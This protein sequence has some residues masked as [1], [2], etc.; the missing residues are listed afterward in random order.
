MSNSERSRYKTSPCLANPISMS[1]WVMLSTM[2]CLTN[3]PS[4]TKASCLTFILDK[5]S[6]TPSRH[7]LTVF[8]N[9][10][11]RSEGP[12]SYLRMVSSTPFSS[13]GFS[14]MAWLT[15]KYNSPILW[16]IFSAGWSSTLRPS[17]SIP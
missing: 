16:S 4:H 12:L 14:F 10:A 5:V 1:S 11:S 7:W 17:S 6:F 8:S 2:P 13:S 15:L 3:W 9:T